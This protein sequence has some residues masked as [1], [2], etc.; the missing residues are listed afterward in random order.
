MN[1]KIIG[2]IAIIIVLSLSLASAKRISLGLNISLE[3]DLQ[4]PIKVGFTDVKLD[5]LSPFT[6]PDALEHLQL[7]MYDSSGK[8]VRIGTAGFDFFIHGTGFI[9]PIATTR[10]DFDYSPEIKTLK[11]FYDNSPILNQEVASLLCNN[12]AQCEANENYLSC[13]A[14]CNWKDDGECQTVQEMSGL[15]IDYK[16]DYYC[17][18][19][20]DEDSDCS[21]TNNCNNNPNQPVCSLIFECN[22]DSICEYKE[23]TNT[24]CTDCRQGNIDDGICNL[25]E[26]NDQTND[27]LN[28]RCGDGTCESEESPIFCPKDCSYKTGDSC[29]PNEPEKI[30]TC[31]DLNLL[32]TASSTSC[33]CSNHYTPQQG[34]RCNDVNCQESLCPVI[35]NSVRTTKWKFTRNNV[36]YDCTLNPDMS[37]TCNNNVYAYNCNYANTQYNDILCP[38]IARIISVTGRI[39]GF[40]TSS[41]SSSGWNVD[42]AHLYPREQYCV[43][44]QS[45]TTRQFSNVCYPKLYEA[46]TG[47]ECE[48]PSCERS[49][50]YTQAAPSIVEEICSLNINCI[51]CGNNVCDKTAGENLISCA[52]DCSVCGD[53][54]K[55]GSE[56]CEINNIPVS[57]QQTGT[58]TGKVD[59][60]NCKII[61]NCNTP[62][63]NI[64]SVFANPEIIAPA[65]TE[66]IEIPESFAIELKEDILAESLTNSAGLKLKIGGKNTK[67]YLWN[68]ELQYISKSGE[69]AGRK[70]YIGTKTMI[71]FDVSDLDCNSVSSV[72]ITVKNELY[73]RIRSKPIK[74]EKIKAKT[75]KGKIYSQTLTPK[76]Q[77]KKNYKVICKIQSNGIF[78]RIGNPA[79][80][81]DSYCGFYEKTTGKLAGI[82]KEGDFINL[83]AKTF[84]VLSQAAGYQQKVIELD[85]RDIL[86]T[87]A[88][89]LETRTYLDTDNSVN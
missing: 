35:Q 3:N 1:K 58:D 71:N 51:S 36:Q 45:P 50:C 70:T 59:C 29:N 76:Q 37:L 2:I 65:P 53:G 31:E 32:G 52:Q 75:S 54:I 79:E 48:T 9:S 89:Q 28:L 16:H 43:I 38:R 33:S 8:L 88:K 30:P 84:N 62:L 6:Y 80:I 4:N 67:N 25:G 27:C 83:P 26:F 72:M 15:T 14:D 87:K 74:C 68:V 41:S 46:I 60:Y 82:T 13:P 56:E 11:V 24:A 77:I 73:S 44:Q 66:E 19:N 12:N 10:I 69:T 18:V 49:K 21:N 81:K 86:R 17:D 78:D 5:N 55:S 64:P 7:R 40:V 42:N 47:C 85:V 39:I 23:S 57:C 22:F 20:C 61:N 63:V 34:C